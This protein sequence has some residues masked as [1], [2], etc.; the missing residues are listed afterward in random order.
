MKIAEIK[1]TDKVTGETRSINIAE[2]FGP[3]AELEEH[4]WPPYIWVDGNYS[5]DCNRQLFFMRAGEEEEP[6]NNPCGNSRYSVQIANDSGE[7]HGD[8]KNLEN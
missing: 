6:E 8:E 3:L 7:I 1:I 5:C 4:D 2:E